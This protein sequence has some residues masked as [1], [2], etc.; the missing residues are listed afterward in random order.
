MKT[1]SRQLLILA[2][3]VPLTLCAARAAN[4]QSTPTGTDVQTFQTAVQ[5]LTNW[6]AQTAGGD[7]TQQALVNDL[8]RALNNLTPS[9]MTAVASNYNIAAFTNAVNAVLAVQTPA[10]PPIPM[11]APADPPANLF[12]PN[13]GICALVST[14]QQGSGLQL[15]PSDPNVIKALDI[16][17]A[18]AKAAT[19]LANAL[20][21]GI[22]VVAGEG[23]TL[24]QCIIADVTNVIEQG[25]ERA[26]EILKFCDPVAAAA[27][28]EATWHNSITIDGD[29][30]T[31]DS[32]VST[33]L[34]QI[35][36]HLTN[37]DND[38]AAHSSALGIDVDTHVTAVNIDI[39]NRLANVDA[40]LN[41][42][43]TGTDTDLNT[44][45][46]GVDP[47]VLNSATPID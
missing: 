16:G 7:P 28:T 34:V 25:L 11:T 21:G 17:I 22:V 47:D 33:H 6:L 18:V 38:L 13:F 41:N 27:E 46:T 15:V 20:C 26:R 32:N 19:A 42:H 2:L 10:A 36:N 5:N 4:A 37:I 29:L 35:A 14:A 31:H 30:A 43:I 24:P 12:P 9:Q 39:D 23:T 3:I 8:Q 1:S 40:D 44:H 45:L